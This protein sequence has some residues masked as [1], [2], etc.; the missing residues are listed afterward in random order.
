MSG[1]SSKPFRV[2][3]IGAGPIG[4]L[5]SHAFKK[6][7]LNASVTVFESSASPTAR[8]REWNFGIYWAL[9]PISEVLD[10]ALAEEVKSVQVDNSKPV[11]DS[12]LPFYNLETGELVKNVPVPNVVRL[13]RKR[14]LT[15][16]SQ[17]VDVRYGKRVARVE[18]DGKN[19]TIFFDDGTCETGSLV[20]GAEGARSLTRETLLGPEKA[21]LHE[22]GIIFSQFMAK[23][24]A[25]QA[26]AF[27]EQ[28]HPRFCIGTYPPGH[29]VT[30]VGVHD[31]YQ[32]EPGDWSFMMVQTWKPETNDLIK[33]EDILQDAKQRAQG[34]AE[35]FRSMWQSVP[36]G[37]MGWHSRLTY[38]PTE[39]WDDKD[40]TVTLAGDSAHPMTFHRG[41]GLNNAI[42]DVAS[43]AHSLEKVDLSS[44]DQVKDALAGYQREVC[45]RG[46]KAVLA[47]LENSLAV[48]DWDTL[49]KSQ[50]MTS[51][52][53][54]D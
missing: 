25:E 37:T 41:Q 1:S 50:L 10:E 2:L 34:F 51:G 29:A 22:T 53:K 17:G 42:H 8:A 47:S 9:T 18:S 16:L 44:H 30:W 20:I 4:L 28:L 43:L 12:V 27:Q 13:N 40:G 49:M 33:E 24:P 6:I 5:I 38:W 26:R 32:G 54:R 45:E 21:A 7:G 46:R 23:L 36:E 15:L 14:F 11:P 39:A 52:F 19:P 3:V 48:H 35:P 31:A